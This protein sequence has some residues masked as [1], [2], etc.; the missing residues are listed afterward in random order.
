MPLSPS[1]DDYFIPAGQGSIRQIFPGVTLCASAGQSLMLSVVD[2]EPDAQVLEHSHPHEQMGILI[3]GSLEFTIGGF[4]RLL[5]PGDIWR[6][7]GGVP[8]SCIARGGPVRALDVFSPIREDY[9]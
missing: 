6:I 8:H 3:S 4:T 5:H 1:P 7:P 9:L 2:L